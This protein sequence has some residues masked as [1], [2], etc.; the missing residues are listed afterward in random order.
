MSR[1]AKLLMELI[2]L[3]SVNP[4]F[5]G[6]AGPLTGERRVAEFLAA[7][8]AK[9]GLDVELRNVKPGRPNLLVVLPPRGPVRQRLLLAPHLDT[10]NLVHDDQLIPRRR[11]G[12]L[13]GRGACD[14]KG[15]VAAMFT[16]LCELARRRT[17]PQHTEIVFAGLAD[18]EHA[19][20]G[21]RALVASGFTADLAIVGEPTRLQVV[22]AHKGSLWLRVETR[23][24]AAHG[25]EPQRGRNAVHTMARVVD[26]LQTTYAAQLRRR[27]HR[28]LGH[29]TVSVGRID[30]GGQ[31]NIVPDRC[32]IEVDRR[33]LP[34][35]T[36]AGVCRELRAALR[37]QG[38]P[39]KVSSVKDVPCAPLATDPRLPL[40]QMFLR[41]VG[42]RRPVGVH[43]FCDA[44]V[45]AAG[46]IPSV[47]FGPG[48]IA[49][50]HTADEWISLA[51]LERGKELLTQF[52]G[53]LP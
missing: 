20:T 46:G 11:H 47:V 3:P 18:E 52:L 10:V 41:Q 7:T 31:P 32:H 19:Q 23:G 5:A 17:R 26:F 49:Q 39:A 27:R 44:A 34:G 36:E 2:A 21:S 51:S 25:A 15:T 29:A 12:R 38:L 33:T 9:A 13:Y 53:A 42:Q 22:T 14:T 16:A 35:E 30:G 40:V 6:A 24:R 4:A 1:T 50:A 37:Q 45:L 8:A 43:Y 28:L 48:D